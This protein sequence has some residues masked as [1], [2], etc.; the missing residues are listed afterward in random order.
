[1]WNL[2]LTAVFLHRGFMPA[3]PVVEGTANVWQPLTFTFE[4]PE[5]SAADRSPNP[6]R[7]YRL[8]VRFAGPGGRSYLVPGY[9]DGDGAGGLKGRAWRARFSPDQAGRWTFDASLRAGLGVAVQLEPDAG[10]AVSLAQHHGEFEVSPRDPQAP[11]FL[12]W[13]RLNYVGKSYLKFVDGPYWLR[14]GTD[15]PENFLAYAGFVRTKPSHTYAAHVSDWREGDPDWGKG[16][17]RGIIGALNSLAGQHVN[18]IY[19]LTMNIGGDGQDVWPWLGTVNPKGHHSNDN[20]HFDVEKLGQWEVVLAH[21]QRQGIFLHV[22]LNE[23]EEANKRELDNGELG[24]ERKLYYR[25]LIARFG[26]HLAM[27]WNLCEE[28]NLDFDFGPERLRAF[29]DY[30]R[31]VD[32]F[33]HPI[34]VHSA[35]D[36]VE[37]LR[38]TYG[39]PR[40]SLTSIQLNQRP[41]HEVTEAIRRATI[42]AGRPLPVSLDEFT[43]DRGQK[44][45]HIPVD[46]AEGHRREKIWPTYFSGGMLEFIL[47]DLLRTDNFKTPERVKLWQY[48]WY[49]RRFMEN[50]LP[51]WDMEPADQLASGGGTISSGILR[52]KS[53]ALGPQVFSRRGDVYAV[54]LPSGAPSATLDLTD[55][56]GNATKRWYNP[57]TGEFAGAV[58][59]LAGGGPR[60]IGS[61][62][63]DPELDWVVLIRKS[64]S[65]NRPD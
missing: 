15:E 34:T 41:I 51:F 17:G 27:E 2:I 53:V 32:P 25:E 12:K 33:D 3:G 19:F 36:P 42:A 31:A 60:E 5:A 47:D 45:S 16:A 57:R 28:Y 44:A 20:L 48:L 56:T 21:A 7:D 62:P 64:P 37:K 1:M 11:G 14:G 35:G 63:V 46:D 40:F 6:F 10:T 52:N 38:F 4:G 18:S 13:G 9:F 24:L 50:E 61:P 23:A 8:Q 29:A 59:K 58:T 55:L 30:I 39:D 54:Y 26:H 43:L 65:G 22:V 49:A